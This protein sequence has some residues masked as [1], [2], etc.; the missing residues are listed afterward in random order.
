MLDGKEMPEAAPK[1]MDR[2]AS[3]ERIE[4]METSPAKAG[5]DG[6]EKAGASPDETVLADTGLPVNLL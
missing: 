4:Q 2:E 6:G 3:R 5:A 1:Q